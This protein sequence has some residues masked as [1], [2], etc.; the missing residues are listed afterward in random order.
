[1]DTEYQNKI[2]T[3]IQ[4]IVSFNEQANP[5]VLWEI[6]KGRI[7]DETIK[8]AS[9][10]KKTDLQNEHKINA[11]IKDLE[12]EIESNATNSTLIET[13]KSEKAK[14]NELIDKRIKG[15]LLRSKAEWVDGSEKNSKYFANLEKKAATHK[16]INQLKDNK[17]NIET[18]QTNILNQIK[19]FYQ[20]LYSKDKNIEDCEDSSF[21]CN[22]INTLEQNN[23]DEQSGYLS[24]YECGISLNEM[25]N[26]KSPGSDGLTADVYKIF[27]NNIKQC[28]VKSLNYSY[29]NKNLTELQKQSIITLLP[30][31]G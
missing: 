11:K 13:L 18:N 25:K 30:K 22:E 23:E 26:N 5:N 17:N 20:R 1:L 19:D 28:L 16:I 15:I 6:I 24:E 4:E 7:R 9:F 2:R 21:F 10:K 12:R 27:W 29:N 3:S 14:L 8:Y 31:K